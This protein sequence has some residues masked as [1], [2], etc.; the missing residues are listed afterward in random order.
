MKKIASLLAIALLLFGCLPDDPDYKFE[1]EIIITDTPANL[2]KLNSGYDD[3]NSNLPFPA[4][5]FGIYFSTNRNSGGDNFDII[6]KAIEISYHERDDIL[7]ITIPGNDNYS[8]FQTKLLPLINTQSDELG[9]FSFFGAEGWDYF[10]YA[11]DESGDFNIKF[12]YTQ[13]LD[14]GTYA[15][16][17]RLFGPENATL[18][19]SDSDDLYPT[20]NQDKS[21]LLFCSNREN[22]LFDIYSVNLNSQVLLHDNLMNAGS[23]QISKESVLSSPSN[24]KCPS[25][26][27]DFLVFTSDR[28]G[29]H[30][31]YDLYYSQFANNQ[32]SAPLN[33]GDKINSS[34]N[35]YRPIVIS[36][37]DIDFMIFSSDRPGGKG[38]YDLY[39]VKISDLLKK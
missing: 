35:E 14:W 28:D 21:R 23:I 10:F 1:Y 37:N 18:V 25:V 13:R 30:G 36:F 38:G 27:G 31:G 5:G 22:Q 29:G 17:E 8:S 24:D 15:G 3:Y 2:E 12:V 9:P 19:N 4:A 7:N 34:S 26:F 20:I 6:C 16:Q 39:C 32:W 33:F 11:N